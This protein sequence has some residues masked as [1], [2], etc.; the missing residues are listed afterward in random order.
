MSPSIRRIN[1][2]DQACGGGCKTA[3]S[4]NDSGNKKREEN[5][6]AAV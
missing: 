1:L 5:V 6:F 3:F 2:N 4:R